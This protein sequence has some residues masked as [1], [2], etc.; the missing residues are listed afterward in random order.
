M[1]KLVLSL[2]CFLP[3]LPL[4][5]SGQDIV[6]GDS[7][8]DGLGQAVTATLN[9]LPLRDS[10]RYIIMDGDTILEKKDSLSFS[11]A[12]LYKAMTENAVRKV[13]GVS[14][15]T[16]FEFVRYSFERR[17]GSPAYLASNSILYKNVFYRGMVFDDISFAFH[18]DE[19]GNRY[20]NQAFF[21]KN[22]R[23]KDEAAQIKDRIQRELSWYYTSV[24]VLDDDLTVGGLPPVVS[25][26]KGDHEDSDNPVG[27]GYGFEIRILSPEEKGYPFVVRVMYGPY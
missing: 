19:D 22:A 21:L 9:S 5:I 16:P 3:M 15:G 7:L 17:F 1:N 20:L 23:N 10:S 24:H 11:Q 2:F 4:T 13:C 8:S 6:N 14:F 25:L 12:L 18:K 26:S 27:M